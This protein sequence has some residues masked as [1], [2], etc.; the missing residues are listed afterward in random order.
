[1]VDEVLLTEEEL[2]S[3]LQ[4]AEIEDD[5]DDSVDLSTVPFDANLI[6]LLSEDDRAE[7]V[8]LAIEGFEADKQSRQDWEDRAKRGMISL[9][10]LSDKNL[11]QDES[12]RNA[13]RIIHPGLAIAV[14]HFWASSIREFWK[15]SGPVKTSV[16]GTET[17]ELKE[18]AE[19]VGANMNYHLL[20]GIPDA[21]SEDTRAFLELPLIG[22]AFKKVF[23][24]ARNDIQD[25]F[26][27]AINLYVSYYGASSLER[28]SRITEVIDMLG[29]EILCNISYGLYREID[30]AQF[31]TLKSNDSIKDTHQELQ[32]QTLNVDNSMTEDTVS[33]VYTVLEQVTYLDLGEADHPLPYLLTIIKNGESGE[34]VRLTR[35]WSEGDEHYKPNLSYIHY[36]FPGV[37]FYGYGFYHMAPGLIDTQISTLRALLNQGRFANQPCGFMSADLAAKQTTTDLELSF[38]EFRVLRGLAEDV[39]RGIKFIDHQEPSA[40]LVNLLQLMDQYSQRLFSTSDVPMGEVTNEMPVGTATIMVERAT[41]VPNAIMVTIHLNKQ[42]E[43]KL[44]HDMIHKRLQLFGPFSFVFKNKR[45]EAVAEDFDPDI[46][47][48]PTADPN[49]M[50]A[51]QRISQAQAVYQLAQVPTSRINPQEA[52]K[53]ML[54]ALGVAVDRFIIPEE[55]MQ[56]QGPSPMEQM[57]MKAGELE[58][59]EKMMQIQGQAEQQQRDRE[60]HQLSSE[61]TIRQIRNIDEKHNVSKEQK[62]METVK[63]LNDILVAN[64]SE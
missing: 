26:V 6:E 23:I 24:D 19:R 20:F 16:I 17:Q 48:V 47:V 2:E 57:Q 55:Q 25:R 10:L 49:A 27:S 9:G 8:R 45:Y 7:I 36:H 60:T 41:M 50:N 15:L 43:Y 39:Q 30:L 51:Q 58:L 61:K 18:K 46:D 11:N 22:S 34:G 44:L 42:K 35:L 64:R 62:Q 12:F 59:Q 4:I 13:T 53:F 40:A 14:L 28:S 29:S 54:E 56:Q 21:F 37:G 32:G 1:M 63:T 5:E 3:E 33:R 31:S 38:G 52:E